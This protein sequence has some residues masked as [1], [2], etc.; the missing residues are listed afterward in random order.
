MSW[1]LKNFR[2]NVSSIGL[3]QYF[4]IDIPAIFLGSDLVTAIARSTELPSKTLETQTISYYGADIKVGSKANY[5]D[6]SVTFLDEH[7]SGLRDNF[8]FWVEKVYETDSLYN[9][10]HIKYKYNDVVVYKH[11]PSGKKKSGVRFYGMFPTQVGPISLNHTGGNINTFDV[12]FS[13]DY[14]TRELE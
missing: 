13:Y 7:E 9:N 6:W 3:D 10:S 8:L 14:F 2:S 12:T 5:G 1:S 4:T 11:D